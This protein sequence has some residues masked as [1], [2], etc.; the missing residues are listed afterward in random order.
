MGRFKELLESKKA[1]ILHGALG[2]ELESRGCDVSGKLWSD[3]YLIEDPAAIQTIHEDYIRA[4]ADIVTT[5]TYQATLQGLA[6]VGV[7]ES[8]AEDLI[9]LTVQLAKAVREQVWKSLTKEEKS[10][11]IYPLISGDV[12]PY[13]AFL[14]DGSEYTG[15]YDIYKEGLKNFHRHRIELLLDEGVDLLALETIPNAQ[16]AEALIELLVEDFPQVEAYMSFTSQDGKTISDGSAVVGLAKAIDVSPQVVA[17][18]INC[19]SPS[20][21][22]DFLQAI[23]E[24]TDKP[25]VT[26]PNSGEI[27]DGASQSWQSSRDHSHT[28]LEN[29]SDWQK[30][31]APVVGGCCRT[32]PA[33]I[34]DLSEHLT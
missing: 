28:L 14:A 27:Y 5:S 33:D 32:R 3:K 34:A 12:G 20:L 9:R 18:G 16:E 29:T 8:Q 24:Q 10:E 19:S 7:S 2:T 6:Q 1:L 4:G 25:L 26:Y 15:L 23:A 31:G 22:A 11:R 21:V 30:L 13:A 17:L